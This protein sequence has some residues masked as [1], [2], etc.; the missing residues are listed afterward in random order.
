[1]LYFYINK[2]NEDENKHSYLL[3]MCRYAGFC[4]G[5]GKIINGISG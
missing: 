3:E 4:I 1:M 2:L 5:N